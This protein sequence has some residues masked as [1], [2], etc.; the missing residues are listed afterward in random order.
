MVNWLLILTSR[1]SETRVFMFKCI[2]VDFLL[3]HILQFFRTSVPTLKLYQFLYIL[4][5]GLNPH[6]LPKRQKPLPP[7]LGWSGYRST[8]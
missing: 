6:I 7:K 3:L 2:F 4:C 1:N 8:I 5:Y